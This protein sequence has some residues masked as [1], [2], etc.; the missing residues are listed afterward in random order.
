[1]VRKSDEKYEKLSKISRMVPRV[2]RLKSKVRSSFSALVVPLATP[3]T[4]ATR[5]SAWTEVVNRQQV[6]ILISE[7]ELFTA[8]K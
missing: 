1:M 6:Q 8:C 2:P 5:A 4:N 7:P 3:V